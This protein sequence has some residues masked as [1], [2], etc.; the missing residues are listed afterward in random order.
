MLAIKTLDTVCLDGREKQLALT[1][2]TVLTFVSVKKALQKTAVMLITYL[3]LYILIT[4]IPEIPIEY[5][6]LQR[7][8]ATTS[9]VFKTTRRGCLAQIHWTCMEGD[10]NVLY[11]KALAIGLKTALCLDFRLS[12]CREMEQCKIYLLL[13]LRS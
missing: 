1:A 10:Q 7:E 9:H 4:D 6:T 11:V 8:E 3:L 5:Y 2:C 13:V 12:F